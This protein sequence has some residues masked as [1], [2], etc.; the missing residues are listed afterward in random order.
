MRL[1]SSS[2]VVALIGGLAGG[3]AISDGDTEDSRA[4]EVDV[5]PDVSAFVLHVATEEQPVTVTASGSTNTCG[6]S[7]NFAFL[8]GTSLSIHAG[9]RNIADCL[10]FSGWSGAC[11]GH[12]NPCTLVINSNLSTTAD[13]TSIAG[14]RPE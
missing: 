12:A 7:C 5:V 10:Q 11:A 4:A 1:C 9:P 3:C 2:L 13:Y 8:G 6:G 14:C